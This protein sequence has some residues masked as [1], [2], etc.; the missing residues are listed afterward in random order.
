MKIQSE[1][2]HFSTALVWLC[3]SIAS[4]CLALAPTEAAKLIASDGAA[5]DQFG[6]SVAVHG[7]TAVIGAPEDDDNGFDSGSA[8]IFVRSGTGWSEQA[9]LTASDGGGGDAFG[10]SVAVHGDTAVIGAWGDDGVTTRSGA[11]Y[12]FVR[13]GTGWSEQAK[14]T[15]SPRVL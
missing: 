11:A 15:E 13:T 9:K 8:Y 3:C 7:D 12:V 5:D 1:L 2:T 10:F 4:P 6:Y 14:L